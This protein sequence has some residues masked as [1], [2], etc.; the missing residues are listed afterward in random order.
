MWVDTKEKFL[1]RRFKINNP[2]PHSI[3]R[4]RENNGC[5]LEIIII[6]I[7]SGGEI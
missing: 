5:F 3:H 7:I 2:H 6:I 4:G 1:M